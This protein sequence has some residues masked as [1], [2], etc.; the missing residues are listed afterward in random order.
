M[1]VESRYYSIPSLQRKPLCDVVEWAET[2]HYLKET[3][4]LY[5]YA[6]TPFFIEPCHYMSDL[7][8]TSCIVIKTCSQCGKSLS[9]M[10]FLG[11]MCEFYPSNTMLV[12]DS[13]KQGMR[14]SQNR[15][16]PFLREICGINNPKNSRNKNP[17]KSNSVVNIGLRSGANLFIASAKSAS[18]SK[19]TPARFILM[20]E[21]DAYPNDINGEGDPITLFTQR[22]KRF[23]GMIIMT[24]TPTTPDGAIS[25][26]WA[27]GTAQTWGVVCGTCGAWMPVP[28][29]RIDFSGDV[30]TIACPHCGSVHSEEDIKSFQHKYNDP[31]NPHPLEDD[32]GR[33]RRS[34][35]VTAPLCHS[36]VSWD[37][38]KK[39]EIAALAI[40][41]NSYKSFKNTVLGEAYVP[42]E[43]Y[44]IQIPDLMRLSQSDYTHDCI[45]SD[46]AFIC[47]G[48]DTHDSCLYAETVGF[49][50]DLKHHYGLSYDVL[51]GDP[52]EKDVWTQ[53]DEL[54]NKEYIRADS[55]ILRPVMIFQDSGGHRTNAV[56]VQHFRNKRLIPIKGQVTN[57]KTAQDPLIGKQQKLKMNGGIKGKCPVQMIGVN[58]GKDALQQME[59]LTIAGD[60]VLQYPR[61]NG[62][63]AGY[64][65]G[66]LSE[67]KISGKWI[68]PQKG[69]SCNEPLDCRVYA[70]ACAT[71]YLSKY[72]ITGLD[73]EGGMVTRKPKKSEIIELEIKENETAISNNSDTNDNPS[74]SVVVVKTRKEEKK[75]T[76]KVEE[77]SPE[78]KPKK[79]FPHW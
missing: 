17:D 78:D 2:R 65:K 28:Y 67:K 29:E 77:E 18:D 63:N 56:Y 44:E 74:N 62:Y 59:L 33:I 47:M 21:T 50:V 69:H 49:S 37:S 13:L 3:S 54:F 5:S 52:N 39:Q 46:I 22:A 64:F 23:R 68:A 26:N 24:S 73:Q 1:I 34:Y 61:G 45:P 30:P 57:S 42:K 40:G 76:E 31:T 43:E 75:K 19:S 35:E 53:L 60:K 70:Y 55:V 10:N 4:G 15:I 20:D 12:L 72:Y 7:A 25:A 51:V 38:L 9:L 48:V 11:W 66:L 32:F 79:E 16:R 58:A 6:P 41:E 27:L 14:F 36:F 71:Y 8:K